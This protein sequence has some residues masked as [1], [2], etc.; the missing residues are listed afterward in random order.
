MNTREKQP[1]G[2]ENKPGQV[3]A[4]AAADAKAVKLRYNEQTNSLMPVSSAFGAVVTHLPLRVDGLGNS[5]IVNS[6]HSR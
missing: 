6:S 3:G 2:N 4:V 5:Y 1:S